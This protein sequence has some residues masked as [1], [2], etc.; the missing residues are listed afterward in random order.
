M[1]WTLAGALLAAVAG[2]ASTRRSSSVTSGAL[3][4]ARVDLARPTVETGPNSGPRIDQMLAEVHM[5]PGNPWCAAALTAWMRAGAAS[6][7]VPPPLAGGALARDWI[8][9]FQALD[10]WHDVAELRAGR[11]LRAGDVLVWRRGPSHTTM[12]HIGIAE[13][14]SPQ[15]DTAHTLEGNSGPDGAR[16]ARMVRALGD[17]LL[18]GAGEL[19]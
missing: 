7:R 18:L 9:Q 19:G 12:G 2:V 3:E 14:V 17:P 13:S 1:I 16:V 6:A 5:P 4:A 11:G 10:R 15:G 8:P